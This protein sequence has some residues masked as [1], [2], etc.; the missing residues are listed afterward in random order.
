MK[1]IPA[2]ALYSMSWLLLLCIGI[3]VI[4]CK[5]KDDCLAPRLKISSNQP[6]YA[7]DSLQFTVV[8]EAGTTFSWTG[9]NDFT[10]I[11][12]NPLITSASALATGEYFVTAQKGNCDSKASVEVE[13]IIPPECTPTNNT[14]SFFTTMNFSTVSF[15]INSAGRYRLTGTETQGDFHIEFY[16]DIIL[17]G[18]LVYQLSTMDRNSNNAFMQID[19]SGV[20]S[21][22]QA[23]SGSLYVQ[24][25][26]NKPI[27][28][29]CSASFGNI[30][31]G[32]TKTGSGKL[33]AS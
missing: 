32:S 23:T 8:S 24:W 27:V 9:P 19:I 21:N 17:N 33:S 6:I 11:E 25:V 12:Q 10:S 29:F 2:G 30:Q 13:V 16:S 7:G 3:Q 5:K 26:N 28:T 31:D 1:K 15:Q 4:S 14:I 20:L 22:W 18:N